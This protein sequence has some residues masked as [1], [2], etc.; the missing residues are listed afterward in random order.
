[1]IFDLGAFIVMHEDDIEITAAQRS[2]DRNAMRQCVM[3]RVEKNFLHFTYIPDSGALREDVCLGCINKI[4]KHIPE[5]Q[6]RR[7]LEEKAKKG[8]I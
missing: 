2:W 3:C 5:V 4:P 7:F 1:M 6:G 8:E